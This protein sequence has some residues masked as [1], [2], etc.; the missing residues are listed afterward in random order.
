MHCC[1]QSAPHTSGGHAIMQH[2]GSTPSAAVHP[3]NS[4][5]SVLNGWYLKVSRDGGDPLGPVPALEADALVQ[6]LEKR[7]L[8]SRYVLL[9]LRLVGR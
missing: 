6:T 2:T 7:V 4:H 5:H 3:I 9:H 8:E 1:D